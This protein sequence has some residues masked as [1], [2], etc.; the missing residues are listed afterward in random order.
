M[1][2]KTYPNAVE[3]KKKSHA[4]FGNQPPVLYQLS[5]LGTIEPVCQKGTGTR[6]T[7]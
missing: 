2:R 3:K 5:Y 4:P 1:G 6:K 7:L